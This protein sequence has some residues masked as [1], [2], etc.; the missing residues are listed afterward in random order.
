MPRWAVVKKHVIFELAEYKRREPKMVA[1][2]FA[3]C[4]NTPAVQNF[5][6]K[7]PAMKCQDLVFDDRIQDALCR[8]PEPSLRAALCSSA[9][10][11]ACIRT[12][13]V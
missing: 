1:S 2:L 8:R 11:A 13:S 9:R 6:T 12:C 5:E 4:D 7:M 3:E 10:H